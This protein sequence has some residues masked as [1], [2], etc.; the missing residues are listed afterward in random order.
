MGKPGKIPGKKLDGRQKIGVGGRARPKYRPS[1][2]TI[3]RLIGTSGTEFQHF[4]A[5]FSTH[6]SF[7]LDG[8]FCNGDFFNNPCEQDS[9]EADSQSDLESD[10]GGS[11]FGD[12]NSN[13]GLPSDILDD[14]SME[15]LEV[16]RDETR[17]FPELELTPFFIGRTHF[18]TTNLR[19][20]YF[21]GQESYIQFVAQETRIISKLFIFHFFIKK[22][23]N[24]Q[25]KSCIFI[26]ISWNY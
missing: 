19:V 6:F 13:H 2:Y 12:G 9:T 15:P 24:R 25:C 18:C 10:F 3:L 14:S 17:H 21:F 11:E 5:Y 1:F 4:L 8:F 20:W 23:R 16:W 7:L 22:A 26:V